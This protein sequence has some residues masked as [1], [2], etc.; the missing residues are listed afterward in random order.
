[1]FCCILSGK[2]IHR[3]GF[4][5]SGQRISAATD[6]L[7]RFPHTDNM[8]I[9]VNLGTV[10]ILHG[11]DLNDMCHDYMNLVKVCYHRNINIVITTLAPIANRLHNITDVQKW[12]DFNEF[13]VNKFG[14]K[15]QVIDIAKCMICPKTG[16]T[17]FDCFQP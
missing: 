9:I 17:L 5:I 15:Y 13:L 14:D 12:R 1:M 8:R 3:S 16:K 2:Q 11:R 10:D 4:C 6:R 7:K